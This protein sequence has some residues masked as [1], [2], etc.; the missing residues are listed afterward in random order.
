VLQI[1]RSSE[2][3]SWGKGKREG[4]RQFPFIY[5]GSS[6]GGAGEGL[7]DNAHLPTTTT[8]TSET[9]KGSLS[10][11]GSREGEGRK[12]TTTKG[13]GGWFTEETNWRTRGQ[14]L[15]DYRGKEKR[16]DK[17]GERKSPPVSTF[18]DS[19]TEKTHRFYLRK[20]EKTLPG[21][22]FGKKEKSH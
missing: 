9:T 13:R 20:M 21:E 7:H 8:S 19:N 10:F 16:I 14:Y 3:N 4:G 12:G 15:L 18:Q 6:G 17:G 22:H 5:S 2:G 1:T 11:T